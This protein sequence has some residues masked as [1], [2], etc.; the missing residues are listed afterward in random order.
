MYYSEKPAEIEE[1]VTEIYNL[2]KE[3]SQVKDYPSISSNAK[4]ALG[5][6]WQMVNNLGSKYEHLHDLDN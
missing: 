3:V 1:K 6:V 5:V 2:L 4:R